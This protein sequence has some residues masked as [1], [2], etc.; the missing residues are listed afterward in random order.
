MDKAWMG[1]IAVFLLVLAVRLFAAF[2]TPY[3]SSDESYLH[4]RAVESILEG[5]L[6]WNDPLGY[7][8]RTLIISPLFDAILALFSLMMPIDLVL[9]IIPNIFS[10][11]LV[12][13]A[14]LI[15][16]KITKIT[17]ISLSSALL[18]SL[19]P[20]FFS[21]TF[22]QVTPLTLAIPT[23]FFLAYAW[24]RVPEKTW[25][26]IF[27]SLLLFFVFLH[28]LS[29]IFVLSI[30]I[31]ITFTALEQNATTAEYELGLFSI[32]FTLWAQF[33]LY[34]KL[35]IFHGIS[36][37]WQ[38][39]PKE[40]LSSFYSQITMWDAIWQ[41][42]IAP[43]TGGTFALYKTAFKKQKETQ[44]LFSITLVSIVIL[45][46]KLIDFTTGFMLLGITLTLLFAQRTSYFVKFIHETKIAKYCAIIMTI[47][48][49]SAL[50]T[51]VYPDY[52]DTKKQLANTITQEEISVLT[53]L[54]DETSQNATIIAPPTY[55]NYITAIA[56][57][58]NVID[59]Y[60]FLIP[61]INERYKDV[62]RLYKTSFETEAV[63]LFD[64]YS[65]THLIVPPGMKDV[66]YADS[67]C[68]KRIHATN[69]IV[70]EKDSNCKVKVVT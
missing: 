65:A 25:V 14:F 54:R 48:L 56:Q 49:L 20:A 26:I 36:V 55:G 2:Q 40:L 53:G 19:V 16:Y 3:Y 68:F 28:P 21:N 58:K 69:I 35:I 8:G 13:P 4:V 39:I 15:S 52:I 67:K 45:W 23:F 1:A 57:R 9:K 59:K 51:V 30:G 66:K 33:L 5:K 62:M 7:G 27:L 10:S 24:L 12:I 22:N 18:A 29:I 11:L 61:E 37:I 42:G 34:K 6:P 50:S 60:Y 70:Y 63:E 44:L 32:F 31:Y 41:I 17:W 46:F 47:L 38:N 64:K 43:L